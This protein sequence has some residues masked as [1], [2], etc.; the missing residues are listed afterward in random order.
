MDERMVVRIYRWGEEGEE[1]VF[2][3]FPEE[4]GNDDGGRDY[5]LPEGYWVDSENG[6]PFVRG[7]SS[8]CILHSHNGLPVLVDEKKKRAFLLERDRKIER[9]RERA[10]LTRAD[11]ALALGTSQQEVFRWE[12]YE[13]EAGTALLGRIARILGCKTE[14]LI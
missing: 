3:F 12:R 5:L 6:A 14:E 9:M 1:P 11:L 4:D 13:V 2:A 7:E 10:G 8:A